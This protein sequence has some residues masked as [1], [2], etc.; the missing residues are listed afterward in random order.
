VALVARV[1]PR[2]ESFQACLRAAIAEDCIISA[3]GPFTVE[4]NRAQIRRYHIGVL[5]TKDSG[6]AGG[7]PAKLEAARLERCAVII[8][9]RPPLPASAAYDSVEDLVA[10]VLKR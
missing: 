3:R 8:V 6:D 7:V 2:R 5:V 10:A 1:L 4:E 9:D